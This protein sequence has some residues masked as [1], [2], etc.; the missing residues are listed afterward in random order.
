MA[1]LVAAISLL[2]A[3]WSFTWCCVT[4]IFNT[5]WLLFGFA[6]LVFILAL[7]VHSCRHDP[8]PTPRTPDR[9]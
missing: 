5:T 1:L 6:G 4:G 3:V 8:K 2:V 9:A 7:A